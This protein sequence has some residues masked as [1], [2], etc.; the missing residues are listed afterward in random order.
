MRHGSLPDSSAVCTL[1]AAVGQFAC[2]CGFVASACCPQLLFPPSL[3]ASCA[4]IPLPVVAASTDRKNGVTTGVTTP[5]QAKL[6]LGIHDQLLVPAL[7]PQYA[8]RMI[9]RMIAPPARMML[10]Y[11]YTRQKTQKTT[12]SDD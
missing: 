5:S 2:F 4:A 8:M 6:H 11:S 10:P 9:V 3:P 7:P 1:T 12:F